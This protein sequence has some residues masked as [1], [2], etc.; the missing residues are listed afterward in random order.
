[1]A[2]MNE[3]FQKCSN[4]DNSWF[5]PRVSVVMGKTSIPDEPVIIR[6]KTDYECTLC[7]QIKY[8]KDEQAG[9]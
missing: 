2:L 9:G 3:D 8:T 4:C 1:M 5:T 6:T 7:Y